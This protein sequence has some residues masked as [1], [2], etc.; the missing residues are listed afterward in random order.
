M[1]LCI[2]LLSLSVSDSLM[3]ISIQNSIINV[4]Q[5]ILIQFLGTIWD[6]TKYESLKYPVSICITMITIHLIKHLSIPMFTFFNYNTITI[7]RYKPD[8]SLTPIFL[9]LETY[10]FTTYIEKIPNTIIS[11]H[12]GDFEY[13]LKDIS[14]LKIEYENIPINVILNKQNA[15]DIGITAI[16]L[17]CSHGHYDTL[18]NF[19]SY[20][21][22]K[23]M[24][25]MGN[26][27]IFK[28]TKI[29][30][31][32]TKKDS[33][34]QSSSSTMEWEKYTFKSTKSMQN[35]IVSDTAKKDFYDDIM[36][37]LSSSASYA[38]KGLP[39][40]RGYIFYGPPGCG[41]TSSIKA[42]AADENINIFVFDLNSLQTNEQVYSLSDNIPKYVTG[43]KY[44]V[45]FEDFDNCYLFNSRYNYNPPPHTWNITLDCILNIIDGVS[46]HS[47]R[48]TIIT[49]NNKDTITAAS[50]ALIRP[51]RID[52][53]VH[54]NK[55]DIPQCEKI[56][57]LFF[58]D[59]N[60]K[61]KINITPNT[62]SPAELICL[63]QTCDDP[64]Q[65]ISGITTYSPMTTS[66]S[67]TS[68]IQ[69][70]IGK[71]RRVRTRF[72]TITD[73]TNAIKKAMKETSPEYISKLKLKLEQMIAKKNL[74]VQ[75]TKKIEKLKNDSKT[76]RKVSN[77]TQAHNKTPP[78]K[79]VV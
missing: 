72:I 41:K 40:K 33:Q 61:Q 39:Y 64:D 22:K 31:P 67:T 52:K 35:T 68:N 45:I 47:G 57:H 55:C 49:T 48:I 11:Q 20:I 43:D 46:E 38:E 70:K 66:D 18:T 7:Y 26:L 12:Q 60:I 15:E 63:L 75:T 77:I 56:F 65:A 27:T 32:T 14:T 8:N 23:P 30:L 69:K 53:Q 44:F 74:L 10:L 21:Q 2:L 34:P 3:D 54:F 16:T 17:Q 28:H 78:F 1:A 58:P 4:V 59:Y 19:L 73:Y 71:S 62:I 36:K 13:R 50:A 51:G 24:K 9:K 5:L 25:Q 29:D 6:Y 76:L 42:V 37:F 79:C